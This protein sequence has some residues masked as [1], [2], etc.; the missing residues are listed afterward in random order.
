MKYFLYSLVVVFMLCGTAN[1]QSNI[2]I[3]KK[4][5]K[6]EKPGLETA[7][8]EV[9]KGDAFYSKKGIWYRDAFNE[10]LKAQVY[11]SI[12]PA[13]N[14]KT[15]VAALYSDNKEK[16]AAYLIKA[17]KE[18]S[19]LT[20]DILL[21]TGRALQYSGEYSDAID[22]LTRYLN[23]PGKKTVRNVA[24]ARKY[25]EECNSAL[26][27]TKDTLSLEIKNLE[28]NINSGADDYSE[29]ITDDGKTIFFAS[30]REIPRQSTTYPDSRF[31]ENILVSSLAG[32]EWVMASSP[33]KNL[34]TSYC[35]APLHIN[36]A[37]DKLYVYTGYENGGDIMVSTLKKG[38]WKT[39]ED[40]SFKINT[41]G[42]ETSIAF[43]PD[44]KEVW[45]VSDKGKGNMGGKDIFFIKNLGGR[46]WSKPV[47]AGPMINT[48]SDEESVRF[49]SSGDTL[50]FSSCGH[51]TIGGFD[52][53]YSVR[54]QSGRWGEAVNY[55]YPLNT[56]WD[57]LYYCPA[58][59][60]DSSFFF[61]SNRPG[62]TG[63]LDIYSGR[64]LPPE[65]VIIPVV[66]QSLD[67]LLIVEQKEEV[68]PP[69]VV[70]L[71]EPVKEVPFSLTGKVTD[72]ETGDPVTAK[73]DVIDIVSDKVVATT[74]SSD[75]D[76]T[77]RITLPEKKS[78]MIDLHATGFL[79][80][81]NKLDISSGYQGNNY[82][83]DV[84]LVK[85]KVGKKVIL[86][87]ILFE[88]GKATLTASSYVELGRLL[89][90]MQENPGMK[91]EI[92]GHTDKTGSEPLNFKL[93]ENRARAVVDFLVSKGIDS[94]RLEY[95]GYGS[96]QPVADNATAVGRSKNRRVEFKILEF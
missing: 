53:F 37:G 9:T 15:G 77:Y 19:T 13:L 74:A 80:D 39:P 55:G 38:I 63:G 12:N 90:F 91:I 34:T 11:N 42:S 57:E 96:L 93:S 56:P 20:D 27:V 85:V 81:M 54:D 17:L 25:I 24:A 5:L 7:W 6:N 3:R 70:T 16:A 65:P 69:P 79:S 41:S 26:E 52:I 29:V 59:H 1:A 78:Y 31:D 94:S 23:I 36:T 61:V 64:V 60:Q 50:W 73:I 45:F 44:G 89:G 72:S 32:G 76:G 47:N 8:E 86:N 92:S 71:P 62:T 2:T 33:G 40:V 82:T 46:K 48:T 10:Y 67:T 88:T 68:P 87:N 18:D 4:D 28:S 22:K 35:E 49:S 21:M 83:H 95:R 58:P 43:T 84:M 14:Y 51:N 75:V 30:R 66:V